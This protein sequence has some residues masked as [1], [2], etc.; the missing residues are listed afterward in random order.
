MT[1]RRIIRAGC[2]YIMS[3]TCAIAITRV[4]RVLPSTYYVICGRLRRGQTKRHT[5]SL[6][7]IY[8]MSANLYDNYNMLY[9]ARVLFSSVLPAVQCTGYLSMLQW[10]FID[11]ACYI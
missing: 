4:R 7:G 9:N 10:L 8:G 1:A 2:V 5:T 3:T 11:C 6:V